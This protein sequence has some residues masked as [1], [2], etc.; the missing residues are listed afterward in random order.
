VTRARGID[1]RGNSCELNT[2]MP[3][4][5]LA[6]VLVEGGWKY[7]L[8]DSDGEPAGTVALGSAG[9][10]RAWLPETEGEQ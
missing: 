2:G 4:G 3:P 7:A 1:N 5:T 10:V 9:H 8:L 6:E